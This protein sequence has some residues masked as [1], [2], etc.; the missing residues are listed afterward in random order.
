MALAIAWGI[1]LAGWFV[2]SQMPSRY[3]S[4]ARV[5]VQLRQLLPTQGVESSADQ[6]K[7]IE[8]VRQTLTSTVNLVKVVKGTDLART[9]SND[10]QVLE[11]AAGF[12]TAIK[13]TAQ[14]DNLFEITVTA[15]SGKLA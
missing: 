5:L 9:V 8:R 12:Q 13:L 3:E 14:Q 7:D 15:P 6:Q 2:V 10:R 1:C 11:R 4:H